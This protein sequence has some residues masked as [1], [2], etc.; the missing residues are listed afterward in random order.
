MNIIEWRN[1]LCEDELIS[2][3]AKHIGLTLSLFYREGKRTYPTIDTLCQWTSLAANTVS[4]ALKD[5]QIGGYIEIKSYRLPNARFRGHEYL[6]LG[7]LSDCNTDIKA[8]PPSNF[9]GAIDAANEPA[10]DAANEPSK[11]ED[12]KEE[13]E[14]KKKKKK[15]N[16]EAMPLPDW[17]PLNEWNGFLEVRKKKN[18][19]PTNLAIQML[20]VKLDELRKRGHDPAA[21]INE[22]IINSWSGFFEIKD[23]KNGNTKRKHSGFNEQDWTAGTEGFDTSGRTF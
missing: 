8:P 3:R 14:E 21:V 23:Y 4:G 16:I 18:K 2:S 12:K 13:I 9:E 11:F 1:Y 6:F 17:L 10:I 20:I 22:S 15:R 19:T 5:L 7:L